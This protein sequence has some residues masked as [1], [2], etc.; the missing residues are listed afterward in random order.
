MKKIT[1]FV[2]NE[3]VYDFD[4]EMPIEDEQL[5]FLDRMDSD[6][7]K[8]IKIKG[9]L[10]NKPDSEQR[11]T[12]V[13]MNLII[14]LQQNNDAAMHASSAYLAHRNPT[15][16]EIHVNDGEDAINVEFINEN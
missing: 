9:E 6:M 16:I 13:S 3:A 8:G 1:I 2:N 15:L 7:D 12:F 5:V 14:A 10:V 11:A 4:R